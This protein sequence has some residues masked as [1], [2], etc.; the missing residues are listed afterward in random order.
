MC[1]QRDDS[2]V[3]PLVDRMAEFEKAARELVDLSRRQT[4]LIA[5]LFEHVIVLHARQGVS[6]HIDWSDPSHPRA[7]ADLSIFADG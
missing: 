4:V 2:L 1:C 5:K 7:T 6:G 3:D